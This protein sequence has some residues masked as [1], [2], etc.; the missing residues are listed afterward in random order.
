MFHLVN[1]DL[2]ITTSCNLACP[3]CYIGMEKLKQTPG[4]IGNMSDE[5]MQ[6]VLTIIERAGHRKRDTRF[7]P[8]GQKNVIPPTR[9]DFYGGEPMVV[10]DRVKYFIEESKKRGMNLQ[11][12]LLTNGTLGTKEQFDYLAANNCWIQRS[13]D[14]HPEAQEKYRPDSIERYLEVTKVIRDFKDSRRMTIQPEFAKDLLQSLYWFEEHGWGK[15]ISPMPNYYTE[16][17]DEQIEDFKRSLWALGAHYVKKWKEGDAFYVF[18]FAYEIAGRFMGR[19]PYGCGGARTLHCVSWDGWFYM[20]HRFSKEPHDSPFCYG[21]VKDV[22]GGVAKGYGA[23]VKNQIAKY[24]SS[25]EAHWNEECR[26]CIAQKGCDKGCIHTNQL[27]TGTLDHPPKLYC[28]IRQETVKVID[29]INEQ[30]KPLDT[31]WWSKGNTTRG[32]A[33]QFLR[34]QQRQQRCSGC[35]QESC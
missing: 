16:W 27:C 12:S 1:L 20:C 23:D 2:E 5:I 28:R 35:T 31:Q 4:C 33:Q 17:S 8:N 19:T 25:S 21:S 32:E 18:Y 15:G 7:L 30:L 24:A 22:L 9:V 10:F 34:N 3:Y 26:Y 14:G 11:F 29:W 6:D 13:I